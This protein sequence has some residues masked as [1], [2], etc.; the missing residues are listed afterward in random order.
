MSCIFFSNESRE[1]NFVL[2]KDK[3]FIIKKIEFGA[4]QLFNYSK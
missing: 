2:I 1:E 4:L 3:F